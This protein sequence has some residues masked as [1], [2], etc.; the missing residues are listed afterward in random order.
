MVSIVLPVFKEME[1]ARNPKTLAQRKLR[2]ELDN[3]QACAHRVP[4]RA[5]VNPQPPTD[6]HRSRAAPAHCL[7]M[8][9]TGAA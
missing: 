7:S 4:V 8:W 5:G 2:A 9:R 1:A 6:R 3:E